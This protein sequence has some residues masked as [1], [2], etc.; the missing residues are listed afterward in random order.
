MAFVFKGQPMGVTIGSLR[1]IFYLNTRIR[2]YVVEEFDPDTT[3][4]DDPLN[5]TLSDVVSCDLWI[6][7]SIERSKWM[8]FVYFLVGSIDHK[9]VM[10]PYVDAGLV[11]IVGTLRL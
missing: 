2:V 1:S 8:Y 9:S 4:L 11:S 7:N 10:K 5:K 6:G 3:G